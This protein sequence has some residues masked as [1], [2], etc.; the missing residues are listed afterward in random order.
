MPDMDDFFINDDELAADHQ[1]TLI[2]EAKI[3]VLNRIEELTKECKVN[4]ELS[5]FG[6]YENNM[7]I[8]SSQVSILIDLQAVD[9]ENMSDEEMEEVIDRAFKS[10]TEITFANLNEILPDEEEESSQLSGDTD[11]DDNF[12]DGT[13][14]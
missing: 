12:S 11:G 8:I 2:D 6:N 7:Q 4:L 1:L 13:D 14:F 10:T 5:E 9:T 3:R